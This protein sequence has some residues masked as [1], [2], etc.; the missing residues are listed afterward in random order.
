MENLTL[1]VDGPITGL[2]YIRT[3]SWNIFFCLQVY[4]PVTGGGAYKRGGGGLG[5]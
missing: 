2:A 5:L 4:G 1:H 3:Y